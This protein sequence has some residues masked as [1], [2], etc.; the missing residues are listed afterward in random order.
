MKKEWKKPELEE[1]NVSMTMAG[2]GKKY[3]D[4][5]NDDP[6]KDEADKYS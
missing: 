4:E 2:A 5:F 3:F 1:L 6:D